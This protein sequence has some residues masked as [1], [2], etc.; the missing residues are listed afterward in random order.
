MLDVIDQISIQKLGSYIVNEKFI[1]LIKHF[2]VFDWANFQEATWNNISNLM[3]SV[4]SGYGSAHMVST[5]GITVSRDP[6]LESENFEA[7]YN[8]LY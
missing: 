6:I 2:Y 1:Y 8:S 7:K 4:G 5:D 3:T